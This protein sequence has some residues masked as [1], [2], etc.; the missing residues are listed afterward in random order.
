MAHHRIR[1][2]RCRVTAASGADG[3]ALRGDVRRAL[4]GAVLPALASAFDSLL[5]GDDVVEVGRLEVRVSVAA[6]SDLALA[7]PGLV[8]AAVREQLEAAL[9]GGRGGSAPVERARRS[10]PARSRREALLVYLRRGVLPSAHAGL[11]ADD[12]LS[13]LRA[14]VP[15][16]LPDL[17]AE[18]R[19]AG[20][21]PEFLERL[22]Q[23]TPEAEWPAVGRVFAAAH[24]PGERL[25]AAEAIQRLVR[26]QERAGRNARLDAAVHIIVRAATRRATPGAATAERPPGGSA[27]DSDQPS[28]P[29]GSIRR[30]SQ[31]RSD[32][33]GAPPVDLER[34]ASRE[35]AAGAEDAGEEAASDDLPIVVPHA[36][37]VLLHPFLAQLFEVTRLVG[38]EKSALAPEAL[39][40]AGSLLYWLATGKGEP[41]EFEL[42]AIKVL[43]GLAP[44]TPLVVGEGLL[45]AAEQEEA[46]A[47]VAAAIRHWAV[48]RQ[49]SVASFR[50]GF[51]QRTGL[52]YDEPDGWRLRVQPEAYDVVLGHLPWAI[53]IVKL[54]W[55]PRPLFCEWAAP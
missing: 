48:L 16:L 1:R 12:T 23:L 44:T 9:A 55:M 24:P 5:P 19:R 36:G 28:R 53:G 10:S 18:W 15:D 8:A 13:L 21:F 7:L 25:A 31:E 11:P 26:R 29:P 47:L 20:A 49:T 42:G 27:P 39:H 30:R 54:P 37:L 17:P 2:L 3:F 6:G 32:Q 41:V 34:P 4:D 52:L 22:L 38:P 14:A 43:L 50:A 45:P 35:R 51:L 33:S 46:D 40:R